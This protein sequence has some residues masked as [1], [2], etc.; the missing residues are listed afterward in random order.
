MPTP[1]FQAIAAELRSDI[2]EGRYP[3][4]AK[5]PTEKNLSVRFGV[6]RHTVRHALSHLIEEGLIKSR[7]GA[8]TFVRAQPTD[9]PLGRRGRFH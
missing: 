2:A 1:I 5:L 3:A 4:G 8:G 7:R 9:Y 6:N